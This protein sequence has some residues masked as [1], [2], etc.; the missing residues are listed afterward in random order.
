MLMLMKNKIC[1]WCLRLIHVKLGILLL[2]FSEMAFKK[3][4]FILLPNITKVSYI[5]WLH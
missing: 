1:S 3:M 2:D 4:E 5:K